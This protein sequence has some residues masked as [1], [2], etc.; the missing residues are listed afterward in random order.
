MLSATANAAK[1]AQNCQNLLK[2]ETLKFHQKSR[3]SWFLKI[4]FLR[5]EEALEYVSTI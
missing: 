5:V 1:F 4:K 2:N 3:F